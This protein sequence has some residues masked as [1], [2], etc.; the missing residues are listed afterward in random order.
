MFQL[1]KIN[2]LK[3]LKKMFKLLPGKDVKRMLIFMFLLFN[4]PNIFL[5]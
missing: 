1:F 3:F 5:F 4:I 2:F